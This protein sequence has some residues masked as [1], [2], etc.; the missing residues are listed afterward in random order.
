MPESGTEAPR[1]G[2][3]G[4]PE[5]TVVGAPGSDTPAVVCSGAVCVGGGVT[6][7]ASYVGGGMAVSLVR[8]S[9]EGRL[10]GSVRSISMGALQENKKDS[11]QNN[12]KINVVANSNKRERKTI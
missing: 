8:A 1:L 2:V 3:G 10:D 12:N 7:G 4:G 9:A 11:C 5:A 6:N